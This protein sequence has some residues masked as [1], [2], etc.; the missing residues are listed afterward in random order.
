MSFDVAHPLEVWLLIAVNFLGFILGT[1]ITS[2]SYYAYR[3][4]DENT[5]LRNAT[6]GFGLLTVGTAIEP[7]YQ[8]WVHGSPVLTNEE[9]ITI[10]VVE[11]IVIA[12]GF[13]ILF[14]SIYKYNSNTS[15]YKLTTNGIDSDL[16]EKFR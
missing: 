9:Y 10:Q 12:S 2:V 8:L 16:P 15:R 14:F 6:V 4:S 11:G 5:S 7:T 1:F 3:S 13:F